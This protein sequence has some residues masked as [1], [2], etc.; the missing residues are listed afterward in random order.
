MEELL[1]ARTRTL[2]GC[3]T[4]CQAAELDIKHWGWK[5]EDHTQMSVNP[6]FS[7][8]WK[9]HKYM[10]NTHFFQ[11][12]KTCLQEWNVFFFNACPSVE[13]F[14]PR[15]WSESSKKDANARLLWVAFYCQE[16]CCKRDPVW[17]LSDL[18]TLNCNPAWWLIKIPSSV[19]AFCSWCTVKCEA[20]KRNPPDGAHRFLPQFSLHMFSNSTSSPWHPTPWLSAFLLQCVW[21]F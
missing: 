18:L 20:V 7:S 14:P 10:T 3:R 19:Q 9:W 2:G 12:V 1:R 11:T 8:L 4:I 6:D 16:S 5:C 13:F 17:A 15:K 21:I